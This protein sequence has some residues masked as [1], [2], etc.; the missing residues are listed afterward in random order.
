MKD[1]NLGDLFIFIIPISIIV[2]SIYAYLISHKENQNRAKK[3]FLTMGIIVAL[4]LG[5]T[6]FINIDL[7]YSI[8][9]LTASVS[10]FF[11]IFIFIIPPFYKPLS[12]AYSRETK[13]RIDERDIMFSRSELKE[14][15]PHFEDY[16]KRNPSLQKRDDKI[17]ANPGLMGKESRYY[18]KD[19]FDKT[20]EVFERI[21][22]LQKHVTGTPASTKISVSESDAV[23]QLSDI[24]KNSGALD[25]GVCEL[26]DNHYYSI[27]GRKERYNIPYSKTH[28]FAIAFTVEMDHEMMMFAPQA[29][30]LL[31]SARQYVN[32]ADI[33][34]KVAEEIR[35]MGFEARAHID[36]NYE[37]VAP[38]V[39]TDAGLGEIGRMGILM[40]PK[41]GPRVRIG[42]VT[43]NLKLK[44]TKVKEDN[45][46]LEFC[47]LCK[48]CAVNC[49]SQAISL[50]APTEINGE[51]RWKINQEDC[52]EYWTKV[53]T[54]C[55]KCMIVCPYSH[56]NNFLHNSI[57]M[58]IQKSTAFRKIALLG[59]DF[60][61][62]KK[63]KSLPMTMYDKNR[64]N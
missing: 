13:H 27:G 58:G 46:V 50:T 55:G 6:Y 28:E 15:D 25:V 23:K 51:F 14:G 38:M 30:T 8:N 53:G 19:I 11:M 48:K 26:R 5:S 57:R 36:G 33:A 63:P 42:I 52:F 47:L 39:A 4:I 54:D 45:S 1:S 43:T 29:P 7:F 60:F 21:R 10:L 24:A 49:P 37:V 17:R 12:F 22:P 2:V 44:P 16:Y 20:D 9:L 62:G 31:E 56:P 40:T 18:D 59:D 41:Q 3:R 34:I 64:T 61:Y 35:A 32:A